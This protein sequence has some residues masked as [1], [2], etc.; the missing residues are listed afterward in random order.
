MPIDLIIIKRLET[1]HHVK[2]SKSKFK[3]IEIHISCLYEL[4]EVLFWHQFIETPN[5]TKTNETKK[6]YV[7]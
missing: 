7:K 4:N 1:P 6:I 3:K 5:E 2:N